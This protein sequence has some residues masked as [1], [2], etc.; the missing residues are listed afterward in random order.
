VSAGIRKLRPVWGLPIFLLFFL[1]ATARAHAPIAGLGDFVNG[2]V[3]PLV[4]PSHLLILIGLGLLIG[5]HTPLKLKMPAL[6]F[7]VFSALALLLTTTSIIQTVYVP[8]LIAIALAAGILVALEKKLPPLAAAVLVAVAALAIGLDSGVTSN[9]KA[10]IAKSLIG[11]WISL[12]V[13]LC[14]VAIYAAFATK[15]EWMKVG[16]RVLGAWIIAVAVLVLAFS[17][18]K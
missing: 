14:D 8:V 2:I 5:Q 6:I 17:L 16:L 1:P 10:T 11:T 9:S 18:Q 12:I 13:I 4:T 7:G 15:K 3:H